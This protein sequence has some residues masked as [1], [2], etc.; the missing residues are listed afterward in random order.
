MS[1]LKRFRI[2]S[3][4]LC[5]LLVFFACCSPLRKDNRAQSPLQE[6][7]K[8]EHMAFEDIWNAVMLSLAK[9]EFAVQKEMRESGFIYAQAIKNPDR[10]YLPPHMN[11]LIRREGNRIDVT[12]HAVVPGQDADFKASSGYVQSFFKILTDTLLSLNS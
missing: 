4:S 6:T 7:K 9:M 5:V 10:L 11:I 2:R 1:R 12:C 8:F 3:A